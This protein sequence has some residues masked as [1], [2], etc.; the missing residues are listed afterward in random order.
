M[1]PKYHVLIGFIFSLAVYILFPVTPL[2]ASV[3][4]LS[5]FLIDFDHYL[6]YVFKKK[7][8]SLRRAYFYLK[9][10]GRKKH[11]KHLMIFHTLEF[12]LIIGVLSLFF[13]IFFFLL[14][15]ILF[16]SLLD[17]IDLTKRDMLSCREFS[18]INLFKNYYTI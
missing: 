2:Q 11:K 7:D 17:I 12:I 15:G 6:W 4:F 10:L 5:S 8:L 16:H 9:S 18:L 1:L 13:P 3:I 14:I